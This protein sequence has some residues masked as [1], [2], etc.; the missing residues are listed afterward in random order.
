MNKKMEVLEITNDDAFGEFSFL[1]GC[2]DDNGGVPNGNATLPNGG[3]EI[4]QKQGD[5]VIAAE[6]GKWVAVSHFEREEALKEFG[7]ESNLEELE[8]KLVG[9]GKRYAYYTASG[10]WY[11]AE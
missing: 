7:V 10:N 4:T 3:E 2:Y 11:V 8:D 6:M 1:K 5:K 9:M